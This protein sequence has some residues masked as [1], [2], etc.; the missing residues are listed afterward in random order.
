MINPTISKPHFLS[1]DALR[2]IVALFVVVWHSPQFWSS[3]PFGYTYLAVDIFFVLS[4]FVIAHAYGEK[5]RSRKISG[6]EFLKIRIIRLYPMYLIGLILGIFAYLSGAFSLHNTWVLLAIVTFFF[7]PTGFHPGQTLFAFNLPAWSLFY[8]LTV[9]VLYGFFSELFSKKKLAF[10]ITALGIALILIAVHKDT[11]DFGAIAG[12]KNMI[13]AFIRSSF[14]ILTG[15]L[16]Y[17]FHVRKKQS[18]TVFSL[19]PITALIA[20]LLIPRIETLDPI[21]DLI[22]IFIIIPYGILAL[23]R[24]QFTKKLNS[25]CEF[26]GRISYPLYAIHYPFILISLSLFHS[27][28]QKH[29]NISGLTLVVFLVIFSSF[30][31]NYIESPVIRR[32]RS[33]FLKPK[34]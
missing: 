21:I 10:I 6:W 22:A 25:T 26:L 18:A 20:L 11:I 12:Y 2:G 24:T 16:I 14:G 1:L 30:V 23:S 34:R 13:I 3:M 4:G 7:L 15:I 29:Q 32:F 28:I 19:I 33:I 17:Q 31:A 5:L 27:E 8:E 9:N